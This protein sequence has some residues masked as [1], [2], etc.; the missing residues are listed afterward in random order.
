MPP[1]ANCNQPYSEHAWRSGNGACLKPVSGKTFYRAAGSPSD[2]REKGR[3][4]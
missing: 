3:T 1:C 4:A 2:P